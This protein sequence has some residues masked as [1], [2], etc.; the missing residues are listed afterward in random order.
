MT[1]GASAQPIVPP[2]VWTEK[3]RAIRPGLTRWPRMA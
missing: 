3:A 2:I 1:T